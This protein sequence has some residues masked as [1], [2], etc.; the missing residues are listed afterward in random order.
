MVELVYVVGVM[1]LAP[2]LIS[3]W[4]DDLISLSG[5]LLGFSFTDVLDC[6]G[7]EGRE[8]R[9][10]SGSDMLVGLCR[11]FRIAHGR[12]TRLLVAILLKVTVSDE[13]VH[14]E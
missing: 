8:V 14:K 7:E 6:L 5:R 11:P 3:R 9:E 12:R 13:R 4:L 1:R 10:R 2:Q